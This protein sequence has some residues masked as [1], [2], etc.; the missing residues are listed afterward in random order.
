MPRALLATLPLVA[1]TRK[2][3]HAAHNEKKEIT[4]IIIKKKKEK[5]RPD[6]VEKR[7]A[8]C[9]RREG[10]LEGYEWPRYGIEL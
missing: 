4:I 5:N 1:V 8:L 3:S 9:D 7:E 10:G 2:G 6:E